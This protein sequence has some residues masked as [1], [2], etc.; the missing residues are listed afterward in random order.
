MAG[1]SMIPQ[2]CSRARY[3]CRRCRRAGSARDVRASSTRRPTVRSARSPDRRKPNR[4]GGGD[5]GNRRAARANVGKARSSRDPTD[6]VPAEGLSRIRDRFE[7]SLAQRMQRGSDASERQVP[8]LEPECC[9]SRHTGRLSQVS[10]C[11]AANPW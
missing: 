4:W 3:Q 6:V 8:C 11:D 10:D 5:S 9:H 7:I 1:T 2:A